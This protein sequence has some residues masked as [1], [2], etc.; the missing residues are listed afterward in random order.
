MTPER[1]GTMLSARVPKTLVERVDF[2]TRN[3]DTPVDNRSKA[4]VAA[5]E[6]WVPGQE[7]RLRELGL[8]PKKAR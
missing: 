8:L 3:I 1:K 6:A 2:I 5:L 4:V 7:E